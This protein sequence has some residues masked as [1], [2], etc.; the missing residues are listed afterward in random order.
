MYLLFNF[1]EGSNVETMGRQQKE[2]V[3]WSNVGKR[4]LRGWGLGRV[5][6]ENPVRL[7][8]EDGPMQTVKYI[9][10]NI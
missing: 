9:W 2:E 7:S 3:L 8:I 4:C 10:I 1:F 6:C 5:A